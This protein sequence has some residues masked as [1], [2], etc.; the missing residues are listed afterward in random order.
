MVKQ[1]GRRK[2]FDYWLK[3]V[4]I[5]IIYF[6][7]AVSC[8]KDAPVDPA[9]H[10]G[11]GDTIV[12]FD[13]VPALTDMVVYEVNMLAFG[14]DGKFENVIT[15]LD[16]IK[17]LGVNVVWL[18]PVY[19]KGELNGVSS[20]YS[21]QDYLSVN[22]NLGT[23]DD[24]K[25]LVKEVHKREMAVI[26][27]WVANHTSWD[28]QW[29]TNDS[30]YVKD[31]NGNII[32]PPGTT[33]TD[34]AELNYNN[35][36]MKAEMIR[37]MKFWISECNIDGFRCDAVDFVPFDFWKQA[38]DSL[39]AMPGRNLIFLAESGKKECLTSGFQLDYSFDF[40]SKLKEVFSTGTAATSLTVVN[41]NETRGLPTGTTKLRYI[42]NHDIYAWENPPSK[43]FVNN[44]GAIAAYVV[45]AFMGGVPLICTGQEIGYPSTISFFKLNPIDWTTGQ[46]IFNQ[47]KKV[48]QTRKA[49][50]L[51]I[52]GTLKT[53]SNTDIV[54]FAHTLDNSQL[55]VFVNVRN[56]ETSL[57]LPDDL[58]NKTWVDALNLSD[59]QLNESLTL[60]PFEFLILKNK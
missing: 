42:T 50:S 1:K 12:P 43:Q 51:L 37:S 47:Y 57:S 52:S 24:L 21:V 59:I 11:G 33:W 10:D 36:T 41:T 26:L 30:W 3:L 45:A 28:N 40:Q 18:M 29:I 34:V 23:I 53:F 2:R 4:L 54:A 14:P 8:S 32:S 27:D 17:N 19:P 55:L 35:S 39:K 20:P 44:D 49:N 56:I 38:I 48:M 22:T 13:K 5:S 9:I 60:K 46:V 31:A 7:L 15:R 58:K 25:K 6:S 16:S